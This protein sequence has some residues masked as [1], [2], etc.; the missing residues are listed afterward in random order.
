MLNEMTAMRQRYEETISRLKESKKKSHAPRASLVERNQA[1]V[2]ELQE[3]V[4]ELEEDMERMAHHH[5][6]ELLSMQHEHAET[7]LLKDQEIRA[8]TSRLAEMEQQEQQLSLAAAAEADKAA[9]TATSG[10]EDGE[11]VES[12]HQQLAD[13][14]AQVGRLQRS[15]KELI[16]TYEKLLAGGD[17][18]DDEDDDNGQDDDDSAD[19]Q[20]DYDEEEKVDGDPTPK[21]ERTKHR[22]TLVQKART[23]HSPTHDDKDVDA[24]DDEQEDEQMNDPTPKVERRTK[25]IVKK[26]QEEEECDAAN[27]MVEQD[28]CPTPSLS[29]RGRKPLGPVSDNIKQAG[30]SAVKKTVNSSSSPATDDSIDIDELSQTATIQEPLSTELVM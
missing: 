5:E 23:N 1:M 25:H 8:L 13:S 19:S 9:S 14:R 17:D 22:A 30:R 26:H 28:A 27:D 6:E 24:S 21:V 16:A 29:R 3:R 18:I 7:L 12:L 11:D 10:N 4:E 20:K 2:D 15:K